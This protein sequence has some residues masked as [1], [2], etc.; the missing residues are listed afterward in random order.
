MRRLTIL[1]P[2]LVSMAVLLAACGGNDNSTVPTPPST[3]SSPGGGNSMQAGGHENSSGVAKEARA[4]R[5]TAR[6]F[7]F[8][9][10]EIRASVGEDLAVTLTS[11]DIPHDFTVDGLEAHVAADGGETATA[12]LR[13][14][15]AGEYAF[16]CTLPGHRQAGMEGRLIVK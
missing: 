2:V 1:R 12:G 10:P 4:V 5:V 6:S 14:D 15:R 8:S 16:Y 13:A 9:P 7:A 3:Q 11:E